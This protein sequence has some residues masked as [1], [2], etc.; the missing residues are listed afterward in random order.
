MTSCR[1]TH[2]RSI[3]CLESPQ[4]KEPA[5]Q[6]PNR[7]NSYPSNSPPPMQSRPCQLPLATSRCPLR[8]NPSHPFACQFIKLHNN[9]HKQEPLPS[10]EE[11]QNRISRSTRHISGTDSSV[12]LTFS[13]HNAVQ[14]HSLSR[15]SLLFAIV[16]ISPTKRL[17]AACVRKPL[18]KLAPLG[19]EGYPA[20]PPAAHPSEG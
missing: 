11:L 14:K 10:P 4:S 18:K 9:R 3:A 7:A 17:T 19:G 15:L 16:W 12:P 1:V 8:T 5:E 6:L 13:S 2:R 20:G